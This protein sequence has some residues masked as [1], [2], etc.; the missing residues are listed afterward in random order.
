MS[1]E[2]A[3]Q[4]EGHVEIKE[5]LLKIQLPK[6]LSNDIIEI[7]SNYEETISDLKQSLAILPK[8]K[9]LTNY[10]IF[11]NG[12]DL[13]ETNFN[14]NDILTYKEVS[15][16]VGL[17]EVSELGI[18]IKEKPYNLA[19]IYDQILR[20]RDNIGSHYVD[21]LATDF[22]V[23]SGVTSFN[24]IELDET[25]EHEVKEG[26]EFK[27]SD[28]ELSKI[29]SMTE[30]F[31]PNTRLVDIT[32]FDNV[33]DNFK[34]PIKSLTVSQWSPVPSFQKQK[35]DLL[36]LSL[37]TLENEILQITCHF[38]GFFV[39][40]SSSVTFNPDLK[41]NEK[42]KFYKSYLL[43]DL[44]SSISPLFSKI[45]EEN[46]SN[47]YK[48][49]EFPESYLLPTNSFLSY[50]WVIPQKNCN[51]IPDISRS[52]LPLISNGVDGSDYIKE[53]NNDIQILKE[54]PSNSI[55]E[56]IIKDKL[57]H[58]TLF[59]FNKIATDT[60]IEIVKG[61]LSPMNPNEE[62]EKFIYLKNGIFYSTGNA[63]LD[64]FEQTGGEEA[65][66]YVSSKDLAAI[67][68][69]NRHS[70]E[71]ISNLVTCIVDYMGKRIICQAPVPGILDA[72]INEDNEISEKVVYGLSSDSTKINQDPSFEKPLKQIAE[73]FH[74]KP[75]KV[76]VNEHVKSESELIVSRDTKGLKGT[77]GRNY[78]IDLYRT[79]PRDIEF[80]EEFFNKDSTSY[81]HGEAL[82]R[83]EAI[84]EWWKRKVS[85]LLK[86]GTEKLEKEGKLK[87]GD[88]TKPQIA[89]STDQVVF[90]PDSF[91]NDLNESKDDQNEVREISKFVKNILIEEY[92]NDIKTQMV[93][94]DGVQLTETFHRNGINMRYLGYVA[95]Q[96]E[97]KL[98]EYKK[99]VEELIKEKEKE[100]VSK[101][102]PKEEKDEKE[103]EKKK[104][105]AP[106]KAKYETVIANYKTL[107]K[108]IIIE[109]VA[110][111]SKHVLIQLT[112]DKPT[113]LIPIVV[114]HFLNCLLGN[115][116]SETPEV[117][118]EEIY[119]SFYNA[120]EFEFTKFTHS[121]V[122]AMVKL[123]ALKRF[124]FNLPENFT[125][126]KL[127]LFREISIKFGIQWKSQNYSFTKN[128]LEQSQEN[129]KIQTIETKSSK[130]SKKKTQ[131]IT[132]KTIIRT[133]TFLP[134][135]ILNF[136]P[137]IKDSLYKSSLIDEIFANARNNLIQGDK[138]L[139]IS[140]INELL[141]IQETIYGKVNPETARFYLIIAQFYQD[142]EL[143]KEAAMIGKKAV[144][145]CE[146]SLG[147]DSSD[148]ITSYMNSA[149]FEAHN[150]QLS[151]SLKLYQHAIKIWSITYGLNHPTLINT[152]T[153]L[154]DH[155]LGYKLYKQAKEFLER[156]LKLSIELNGEISEITALI[157]YRIANV[158]VSLNLYKSSIE[159]FEKSYE[160]LKKFVGPNDTMTK[161]ISSYIEN[162][163]LLINYMKKENGKKAMKKKSPSPPTSSSSNGSKNGKKSKSKK[164]NQTLP[165]P[166]IA[167]QSVDAILNFI[168]GNTTSKS[169]KK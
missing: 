58:K 100:E 4:E 137:I 105:E 57:I 111:S 17:E 140:M 159:N 39:N 104:E 88:E 128:Q 157:Y 36:Y 136:L 67:K 31:I 145:L 94:F 116:I 102:E 135:D 49:T 22:G 25:I 84:N 99:E 26:E 101:E 125:N 150:N 93:P 131:T 34:I 50:P 38:S 46:E 68:L 126:C 1:E 37:T 60:A 103:D 15:K 75:H 87:Q 114:S 55:Q 147:F 90:N 165:D 97:K 73:I 163:K 162:I 9:N 27:L 115:E 6:F 7:P 16:I 48:S 53:W 24:K 62:K 118:I 72:P 164:S 89:L 109:I 85:I 40:K 133:T 113:Y 83:H 106:S 132:E 148:T 51:V 11:I 42:G 158:D 52:Q 117:I 81:P 82:I 2:E 119:K 91:S 107:Q 154:S 21:K 79:T 13:N 43:Y 121:K 44:I 12:I 65:S 18:E 29:K 8:T 142:L 14:S 152:L 47:L 63:T 35:G 10:S 169:K 86:E 129:I 130:K 146:R 143:N 54:L 28:E 151:N 122:I 56:R 112:K 30:N 76:E 167:N 96:I 66:R 156:A 139:G 127:Q 144:I 41:T 74:L 77:D 153:N 19:A 23:S 80:I 95:Q 33:D 120:D 155:L 5:L 108:L 70:T 69:L 78:V 124:R 3:Q 32:N 98:G 71:G 45:I 123:E 138:E 61:N 59:E 134:E 20:F 64:V 141:L 161:Q 110:R 160:I 168:E 92:L 149:F 166:E